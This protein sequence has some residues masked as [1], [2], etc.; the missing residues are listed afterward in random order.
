MV[1]FETC[2][3]G[4]NGDM[5]GGVKHKH[6]QW[7][8]T[9]LQWGQTETMVGLNRDKGSNRDESGGQTLAG[10]MRNRTSGDQ[11]FSKSQRAFTRMLNFRPLDT[12]C[13]IKTIQILQCSLAE[14]SGVKLEISHRK[15][16]GAFLNT[17]NNTI[18]SISCV[19]EISGDILKINVE[20]SEDET[21][22]RY[23]VETPDR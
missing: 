13:H 7:G 18:L 10:K 4:S 1:N 2:A 16:P 12:P 22:V 8:Q 6:A 15:R 20:L 23:E 14:H 5:R 17:L 3:L 21:T 11:F 19:E 9:E